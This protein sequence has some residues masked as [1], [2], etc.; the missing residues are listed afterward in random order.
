MT[1][2]QKIE[3]VRRLLD[4]AFEENMIGNQEGLAV[5]YMNG[6]LDSIYEILNMEGTDDAESRS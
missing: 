5:G 4:A 3:L 1:D 2:K 6:L